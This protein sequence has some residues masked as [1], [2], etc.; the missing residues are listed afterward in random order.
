MK[1]AGTEK[2]IAVNIRTIVEASATLKSLN[3]DE[4][5]NWP[6]LAH[7]ARIIRQAADEINTLAKVK[8]E[9]RLLDVTSSSP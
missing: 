4:S 7:V 5:R 8:A 6:E 1:L 2:P 3:H 9:R